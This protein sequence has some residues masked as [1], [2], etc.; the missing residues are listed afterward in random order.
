M[1]AWLHDHELE[2]LMEKQADSDPRAWC[3]QIEPS[4]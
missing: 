2:A 3:W 4:V 1:A